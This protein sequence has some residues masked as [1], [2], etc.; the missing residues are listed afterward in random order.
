MTHR[1]CGRLHCPL[2]GNAMLVRRAGRLK[3]VYYHCKN[4][5][6]PWAK[7]RCSYRRFIP[8]AW[9]DVVWNDICSLLRDDS[10][11]DF[12]LESQPAQEENVEK[13]LRL[14]RFKLSQAKAKVEKVQE[15]FE[16]GIYTVDRA[17]GR[18]NELQDV[19]ESTQREIDR[20]QSLT[21]AHLDAQN[22]SEAIRRELEALRDRNLDDASFVEKFEMITR[23]GIEV[24][25]DE[26]LKSM[27]VKCQLRSPRREE[28][29]AKG[30]SIAENGAQ[31]SSPT[32]CGKVTSAPP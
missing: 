32:W 3:R 5:F 31:M 8:G 15:G 25:P 30:G 11:I 23:L 29:P 20:L 1:S 10:W 13:L 26:D 12:Q 28:L 17:K 22:N 24:F 18:V 4:Y 19:I 27:R 2:C 21:G 14:A 7:E 16:A 9:D 6:K